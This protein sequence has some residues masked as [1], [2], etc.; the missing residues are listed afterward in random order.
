M[1][2]G[3]NVGST[4]GRCKVAKDICPCIGELVAS[5]VAAEA[6]EHN[7]VQSQMW[8]RLGSIIKE[9][10]PRLYEQL[11]VGGDFP[12]DYAIRETLAI[13]GLASWL[14]QIEQKCEIPTA[15]LMKK[16]MEAGDLMRENKPWKA[17][18]IY[19]NIKVT[20]LDRATEFCKEEQVALH[21]HA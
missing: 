5:A 11:Q 19:T 3:Q 8:M 14:S 12:L 20:L 21:E 10:A 6:L 18:P 9:S 1:G 2:H 7:A 16:N 15:D 4:F 13:W 17:G